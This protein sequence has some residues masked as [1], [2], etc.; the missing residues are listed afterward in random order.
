MTEIVKSYIGVGK[1]HARAA[2]TT[3]KF[4][5]VGNVSVLNMKHTLDTQKQR[6]FTRAGGGTAVRVDRIQSIEAAMTWLTFSK[7][8][9]VLATAGTAADVA[10]DPA[11]ADEVVK[12]YVGATVPLAYPPAAITSVKDSAGAVTYDAGDD[13]EMT[14]GGL[15]FPDGSTIVEAANLKVTYSGLAHARLEGAMSSG[16]VLELWYEGLNEADSDKPVLVNMWRVSVPSAEEIALIGTTLGE[17][18]FASELLKDA[19]KG[20]G[21]SAFY[22]ALMV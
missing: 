15:Y 8:N 20:V 11:I 5:H 10:A 17:L 7:E 3:G 14:S 1:V 21:V 6:D 2:G 9:W 12:G 4:R 13:Y 18:K 19:S 22:R 16:T